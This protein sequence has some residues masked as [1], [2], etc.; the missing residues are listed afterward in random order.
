LTEEHS[1]PRVSPPKRAVVTLA[2]G[3]HAEYL[4]L[5]LP[6]LQEYC[7][8]HTCDLVVETSLLDTRRPAAW[9]KIPLLLRELR[10][11]DEILWLDA[12]TLILDPSRSIFDEVHETAELGWVVHNFEG[13]P[14]PNSGVMVLRATPAVREVLEIAYLQ[15]D[16]IDSPWWD[17]AALMRVTGYGI[18]GLEPES[19][20]VRSIKEVCLESGWNAIRH[21]PTNDPIIRHY[22]GDRHELRMVLM[23]EVLML[24]SGLTSILQRRGYVIE[25]FAAW[26]PRVF[27]SA[28][29]TNRETL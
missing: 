1:P 3:R 22:A 26:I 11:Y 9:S 15:E 10:R 28:I 8:I 24:N 4:E 29:S 18:P 21:Y 17:N 25:S 14:F 2:W 16:L 19:P 7:E 13:Q 5:T 6:I 20:P 12:D 23:L 27:E